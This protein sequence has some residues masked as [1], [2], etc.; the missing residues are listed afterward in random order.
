[1]KGIIYSGMTS[2]NT[3]IISSLKILLVLP[4]GRIHK[5]RLGLF[6]I[7]F[8]EAPLT[9]TMLAALVPP[10]LPAHIEIADESIQKIP[11][12]K[13]YDLVGIS[14]MTGTSTRAYQIADRFRAQGAAVVLGGVHVTLLPDEAK[15]HADTMVLGFSEAIWPQLL[16][17][18]AQ[19]CLQPVYQT[20]NPASLEHLPCPRRDLQ[21]SFGYM[22]PNTVMVTRG[23]RGVCDFCTV[24]AVKFGW[25]T[26]P[27]AEVIDEIRKLP[28]RRFAISDVHLTEDPEYAKEFLQALIP[29][30]KSWGGLASTRI[31]QDEELLDLM[32]QS[33]CKFLLIGFES[34][35]RNSLAS[36]HKGF[37]KV[38]QYQEFVNKLHDRRIIIQGCFIFGLDE[39][40]TS[41]FAATVDMVDTLQIDIPRYAIYTPYPGTRAFQRLQAEGRLLHTRWEYYDTQHV[42][43]M[44]KRM[45][46]RELDAGFKWAYQQTYKFLSIVKRT[47]G[48]G[49]NFP[50]TFVGNLA[51]KLYIRRL[52]AENQRFP[53][54][55]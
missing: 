19:G 13:H 7:S 11:F 12:H 16:R 28:S 37:N 55:N 26:R 39:D 48:S 54:N 42:V 34:I 10:E 27:I 29:L 47:R 2:M 50:I 22:L 30:K 40:D 24:P 41:I 20:T 43:F 23:C 25:Q 51:Y 31:G 53:G 6:D 33:G 14:C 46:P 38:E 1:M 15:Q 45:S 32:Q 3:H 9:A 36:I 21:R 5:L 44:P 8:R 4:D 35:N 49:M 52:L 18:F 17:D